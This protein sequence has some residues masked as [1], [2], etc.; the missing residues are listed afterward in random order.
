M[1]VTATDR[2]HS[3]ADYTMALKMFKN[4]GN[5]DRVLKMPLLEAVKDCYLNKLRNCYTGYLGITTM[6]L[7]DHLMDH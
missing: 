1:G 2:E 5:M 6:D 4:Y 7:I 3:R